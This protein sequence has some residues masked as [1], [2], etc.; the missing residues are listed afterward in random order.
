MQTSSAGCK[1]CFYTGKNLKFLKPHAE[2]G[3]PQIPTCPNKYLELQFFGPLGSSYKNKH[4]VLAAIN[5]FSKSPQN[6]SMHQLRTMPLKCSS[7][8]LPYTPLCLQLPLIRGLLLLPG[9]LKRFASS[10]TSIVY[11]R[12]L[13]IT[14]ALALW[15]EPSVSVKNVSCAENNS[16][17]QL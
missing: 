7:N 9:I 15:N 14:V 12:R 11:I 6:L 4:Y 17:I 3:K 8:V 13:M 10:T 16:R 5:R 1:T 2:L